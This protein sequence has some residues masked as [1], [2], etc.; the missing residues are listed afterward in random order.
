VRPPGGVIHDD[1]LWVLEHALGPVPLAAWLILKPK[2]HVE[3]IAE[4]TPAE[5]NR[6]GPL[7]AQ[8]SQVMQTALGAERVYLCS[9]GEVVTHV[10]LYLLPR[11]RGMP[12]NGGQVLRLMFSGRSPWACD[13]QEAAEAADRVRLGLSE[14]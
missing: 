13:D 11:Y 2:R 4:L 3:H 10:H 14:R 8:I 1:P 9:F 7:I 5:A 12:T 6:M